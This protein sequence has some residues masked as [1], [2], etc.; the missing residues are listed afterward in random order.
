MHA[1]ATS[2]A[3]PSSCDGE[4]EA[5]FPPWNVDHCEEPPCVESAVHAGFRAEEFP[6]LCPKPKVMPRFS[7][8]D[9]AEV[10]RLGQMLGAL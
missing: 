9:V 2:R 5:Q 4:G 3:T 6:L 1:C 7:L 10:F 8:G